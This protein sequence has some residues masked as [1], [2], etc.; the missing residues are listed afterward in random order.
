MWRPG[1]VIIEEV[2][3]VLPIRKDFTDLANDFT[4]TMTCAVREIE[5][6]AASC[7]NARIADRIEEHAG[8]ENL[9]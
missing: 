6:S 7:S 3:T 2:F 8:K 4:A 9:I 1:R 5:P